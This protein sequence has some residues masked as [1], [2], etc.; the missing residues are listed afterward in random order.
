MFSKEFLKYLASKYETPLY[1]YD[2]A[3]IK[4]RFIDFKNAFRGAST[5]VCYA[6]KANSN[7]ALLRYLSKLGIGAD[8][9]SINEIKKALQSGIPKYKII[10][11]GV[12][13]S[14]KDI[15][16]ALN[17]DILFIN[18]E[19]VEEM[20]IVERIA[21]S[22]NKIARISIRVNPNID[23]KTHPYISTGL[24][25][26]KFGVDLEDAKRMYIYSKNSKYLNPVGIH[27]H[28]GSQLLNLEPIIESLKIIRDLALS[29]KALKIDL[30]FL[31]IGGGIGIQYRDEEI[32]NINSYASEIIKHTRNLD[33]SLICEPG[34]SI[35]GPYGYLLS[36]VLY[37]KQN[38]Y[39]RFVIIDAAMNDLL[40]P[41][42]YGAF[43]KVE[44]FPL[45]LD[46]NDG[47]SI[48]S[49][50]NS[51]LQNNNLVFENADIVG[52]ICES[53][54]YI[55][56]NISIPKT[57]RGD[58]VLIHDVGAYGFSMSSNYNSRGRAA[59][60]GIIDGKDKLICKREE[61]SDLISKEVKFESS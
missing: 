49:T 48:D 29:L 57:K 34:R 59:C 24:I 55:A 36:R 43:H 2:F 13:K 9:V 52:P 21:Y 42:L 22:L 53:S 16:E 4:K 12:G 6:L 18:L 15:K 60:V 3:A 37:E 17:L 56:K 23:S 5:L 11:S 28:I 45:Y 61:Y 27:S 1:V 47:V 26:N 46:S 25:E 54:D 38:N 50:H 30:R 58:L 33:L 41:S 32:I 44:H 40:R 31:D 20:L 10:Y 35:V 39:K 7:L 14:D 8:C 51:L 19:S